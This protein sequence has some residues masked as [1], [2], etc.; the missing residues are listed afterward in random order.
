MDSFFTNQQGQSLISLVGD[1]IF[2][3]PFGHNSD[4]ADVV[5]ENSGAT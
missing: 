2:F 4:F 1:L 3:S 5:G